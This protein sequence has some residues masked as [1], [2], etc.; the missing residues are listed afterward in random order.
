MRIKDRVFENYT[1]IMAIINVTPDSFYA[2]SR[3]TRD[4]ILFAVEGACRDGAAIIDL[5]GQS[6]RPGY[7]RVSDDEEI[8][9]VLTP[10]ADIKANFDIPVSID[11]FSARCAG[12]SLAAGADMIND[13]SGFRGDNDMAAIVARFDASACLMHGL[14]CAAGENLFCDIENFLLKSVEI[15]TAAGVKKDKIIL[16]GGIGFGK[17]KE[18]NLELLSCYGKL[19]RLGFPILLGTSRKSLFGGE[20]RERLEKTLESTRLAC[21]QGVLFVRVHDVKENA[22]VIEKTYEN[23]RKSGILRG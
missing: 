20:P 3:R 17:T 18:Q 9:R 22:E 7:V 1:Y 14:V 2:P 12:E 4:E 10:L 16:D 23:M 5:G 19:K 21:E 13:V 11:T 6:T 8:E 15:A